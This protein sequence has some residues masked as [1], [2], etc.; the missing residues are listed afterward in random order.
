MTF[1]EE[2]DYWKERWEKVSDESGKTAIR[3]MQSWENAYEEEVVRRVDEWVREKEKGKKKT[4][5]SAAGAQMEEAERKKKREPKL[6]R[7]MWR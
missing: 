2:A 5:R 6:R 4:V 7:R 1:E 3:T